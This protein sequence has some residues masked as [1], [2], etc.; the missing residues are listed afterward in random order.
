LR[1]TALKIQ[2]QQIEKFSTMSVEKPVEKGLF[3]TANRRFFGTSSILHTFC[4][5]S[6]HTPNSAI[7]AFRKLLPMVAPLFRFARVKS[8]KIWL[9]L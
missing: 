8:M 7:S 5:K 4:S 9:M 6:C 2:G 3:R 1:S